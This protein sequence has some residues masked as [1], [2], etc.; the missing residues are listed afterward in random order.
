MEGRMSDLGRRAKSI[1]WFLTGCFLMTVVWDCVTT[2]V[3]KDLTRTQNATLATRQ[4]LIFDLQRSLKAMAIYTTVGTYV[5]PRGMGTNFSLGPASNGSTFATVPS[6]Q[7]ANYNLQVMPFSGST[8]S[9]ALRVDCSNTPHPATCTIAP[10]PVGS[11]WSSNS[12]PFTVM[13]GT[14]AGLLPT[15]MARRTSPG[16]RPE[17]NGNVLSRLLAG[18]AL[19]L[20]TAR[21]KALARTHALKPVTLVVVL[22]ILMGLASCACA[23]GAV[24]GGQPPPAGNGGGTSAIEVIAD[25]YPGADIC[26]KAVNAIAALPPTGGI[27]RFSAQNYGAC[28][29]T[30]TVNS[31]NITLK[32]AGKGS[33]F[34]ATGGAT[35]LNFAAGVTGINLVGD[36]PTVEDLM[37]VS[38]STA[39]GADDGIQ[40]RGGAPVLRR[41]AVRHFGNRGVVWI[42][43][44]GASTDFWHAEDIGS[45]NNFGDGFQW[46]SGCTD[47]HLGFGSGMSA[48]SNGGWGFNLLCGQDNEFHASHV[49]GNTLGGYSVTQNNNYFFDTYAEIG[50]GSSFVVQSG[51]A[52]GNQVWFASFG[53]PQAITD[54]S[55]NSEA[56][57]FFF[58]ATNNVP[59]QNGLSLAPLPGSTAATT[60]NLGSGF[61]ANSDFSISDSTNGAHLLHYNPTTKWGIL[62]RATFTPT[63]AVSGLNVGAL[64]GNPSSPA[65][66]DI[67]YNST[68]GLFECQQAGL[69][70]PC[71]YTGVLT[72]KTNGTNNTSQSTATATQGTDTRILSSGTISGSAGAILCTDANGGV[73]TSGCSSGTDGVIQLGGIGALQN[74]LGSGMYYVVAAGV[75]TSN[76][77]PVLAPYGGAIKNLEVHTSTPPASGTTLTFTVIDGVTSES[78]TCAIVG[79]GSLHT[80]SD[81]T[82]SFS[83]SQGDAIALT[84]VC[85][86]MCSSQSSGYVTAAMQL[87]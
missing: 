60:Y 66:G 14:A 84:L 16:A 35:T 86:G 69:T 67:W 80:C 82:H 78:V 85:S 52:T 49:A 53:L 59:A 3:W 17:F 30:L 61:Y 6:G 47:N 11:T 40:I 19:S 12:V 79:D 29:A 77:A 10:S 39:S 56:N 32:G 64:A 28:A 31:A 18:L 73:T 8:E 50:T 13:A 4:N 55:G 26:V 9:V 23:T 45:N 72:T 24:G 41:V 63:S 5:S 70:V 83:A 48:V 1:L 25:N 62:Q 65:N 74:N 42:G 87:Q 34:Q 2:S 44:G 46:A 71:I 54:N 75:T 22:P 51:G 36:R 58:P 57:R 21:R 76:Y 20:L 37:L 43:G 7:M 68:A 33:E 38:A 81:T 15:A 27:V